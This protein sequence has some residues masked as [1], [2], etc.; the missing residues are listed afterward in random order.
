MQIDNNGKN[1][2]RQLDSTLSVGGG[3]GDD[4]MQ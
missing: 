1:C 2:F 4:D 3:G